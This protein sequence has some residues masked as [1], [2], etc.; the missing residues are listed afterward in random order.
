MKTF[1]L[2]FVGLGAA[3]MS[4]ATRLARSGFTGSAV[5]IEPIASPVDERTWCGWGPAHHPFADHIT[6]RW[7]RWS[8]SQGNEKIERQAPS[9]PYE[10]LRSSEVR[11]VALEAINARDDW[12]LATPKSLKEAEFEQDVWKLTLDDGAIIHARTVLDSR[13][14]SLSLQRPWLWQS[15]YGIEIEG[16]DLGADDCVTLMDF[17]EDEQPFVSFFYELPISRTQRLI[18]YTRFTPEQADLTALK[19]QVEARIAERGWDCATEVRSESGHLPMAAIKPFN[20]QQWI[21]IGTAGGS[22]R[23]ATGYAF[24]AIQEWADRSSHALMAGRPPSSPKRSRFLDWLDGVFLESIWQD[25]KQAAQRYIQLFKRTE[26]AALIRFLMS[27]PTLLDTLSVL[28]ALPLLP[29]LKAAWR[30]SWR[31]R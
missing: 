3:A 21:N 15:F 19:K 25:P 31:G 6:R 14:P 12:H 10:M 27:R 8:V 29:M 20:Q 16:A 9:I 5:F 23:P 30:H 17:V 7:N 13:P 28:R 18:E 24:H 1:E 26:P 22:M 11:A 2:A 4:L